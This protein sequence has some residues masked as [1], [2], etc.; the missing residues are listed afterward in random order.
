MS[1]RA[2][3]DEE[4]ILLAALEQVVDAVVGVDEAD[5]VV[6]FNAVA[7][8][9]WGCDRTAVLGQAVGE[10]LPELGRAVVRSRAAERT[11]GHSGSAVEEISVGRSDGTR[12]IASVSLSKIG[13]GGKRLNLAV[14]RDV[15][16]DVHGRDELRLLSLAADETD[17]VVLITDAEHRVAYING[18]FTEMF[19]YERADILGRLSRE[20]FAATISQEVLQLLRRR[21]ESGHGFQEELFVRDK[22]G[23][24]IWVHAVINPVTDGAGQLRNAVTVISNI[25][26]AKHLQLLQ[27][28]VL[29]AVANDM[30]LKDV[31][32]LICERVEAVAPE[33]VCS[34]LAVDEERRLRCLAAPSLPPGVT[35][36]IDGVPVGPAA[37]SCGTAAYRGEEVIVT[38]VET[39]PLWADFRQLVL[40][41]GLRS[42]WSNPIKLRDGQ[43]AGT[44][45]FYS[46]EKR[47]PSAWHEQ[48]VSTCLHLCR[49]AFERHH[50]NERIARLAYYDTLTGLPNRTRLRDEIRERIVGADGQVAFLFLDIDRFKDVNDTLGHSVGDRLLVEIARRLKTQLG[51]DDVV[52]RYGG[53]EFVILAQACD[54]DR[55]GVLAGRLI[56]QLLAPVVIENMQLPVSAS[57]G[58]SIYP[59]DGRDED[60]LLKHADTAM[61]E[62]KGVGGGSFRCFSPEMNGLAQERLVLGSALREAVARRQLRLHYQ[63][64]FDCSSGQLFGVEA[65]ARWTH[66]MFGEVSPARFIAI[67]EECGLIEA[68]GQWVLNEA[69]EQMAT[70]RRQGLRLP[71]VSINLSAAHFRNCELADLVARTLARHD[72]GPEMLTIE[73]TEGVIMDDNPT[74]IETAKAIHALGVRLSL[75]DFGTGYSSLSY[76]ARL[77]IDEL[78][79]DRSFMADLDHDPNAQ[80]VVTAVVKIGQSLGLTVVAE[81]VETRSQQRFLEALN[82]DVLQGFLFSRALGAAEFEG[83]YTEYSGTKQMREFSGAA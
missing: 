81:G 67:A 78:K 69:C 20:V 12:A 28:D 6:F 7:E 64:Q 37:G 4:G 75:D 14:L 58:I 26:E 59:H 70:W 5:R 31:M 82:C 72:L 43:V 34:V 24:N 63:P 73:I 15:T 33:V 74:T 35:E 21:I 1:E 45:A 27:R 40:P 16:A 61:Y 55:A 11:W 83:W 13:I 60:T 56:E 48:V 23:R 41:H 32:R 8:R 39:D 9:L 76:L 79:I 2:T 22:D 18:A 65:L 68:I 52:S 57:I 53:D 50:A 77:P 66:P 30:Q 36:A 80:A 54:E 3:A 49:L 44:F 62:A 42:C 29:E 46:T 51:P 25:T 17:R 10:R 47:G 19:G 38:D 71:G